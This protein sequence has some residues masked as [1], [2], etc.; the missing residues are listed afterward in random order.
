MTQQKQMVKRSKT[1]INGKKWTPKPVSGKS[2][3]VHGVYTPGT[4]RKTAP[5]RTPY[6]S[7]SPERKL[8][9]F[10]V[11]LVLAGLISLISLFS[12][13]FE[14]GYFMGFHHFEVDGWVGSVSHSH[15]IDRGRTVHGVEAYR[16]AA[17]ITI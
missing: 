13:D 1:P 4:K 2:G 17:Q 7:I 9:I 5:E 11:I 8:D 10:G 15:W 14:Q 12:G 3:V 6:F 16:K